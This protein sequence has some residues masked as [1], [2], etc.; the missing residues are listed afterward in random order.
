M[1][2]ILEPVAKIVT[3]T[4]AGL[5]KLVAPK[6]SHELTVLGI[7]VVLNTLIYSVCF[8]FDSSLVFEDIKAV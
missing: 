8:S 7:F 5:H 6:V 4:V 3:D 1:E 2:E